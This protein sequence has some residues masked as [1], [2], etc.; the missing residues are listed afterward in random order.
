MHKKPHSKAV[1]NLYQDIASI[2]KL[3][4]L[5]HEAI[6]CVDAAHEIVAFNNGAERIFG[7]TNHEILGSPLNKLIPEVFHDVHTQHVDEFMESNT[8]AKLMAQRDPVTGL[9][10]NGEEFTAHASISKFSYGGET[11]M[12]IVLHQIKP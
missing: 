11:T 3:L 12:T 1:D 6:L 7:Y 10:K 9:R 4:H 5:E 2:L 8:R